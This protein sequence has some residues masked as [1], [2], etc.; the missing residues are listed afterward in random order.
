MR[1]ES[2]VSEAFYSATS[3]VSDG[4][5]GNQVASMHRHAPGAN[6]YRDGQEKVHLLGEHRGPLIVVRSLD[7]LVCRQH[8]AVWVDDGVALHE[9]GG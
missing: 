7:Q 4:S 2:Q 1:C 9:L 6:E 8:P 5:V 3:T